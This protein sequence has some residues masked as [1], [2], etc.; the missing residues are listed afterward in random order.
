MNFPVIGVTG[1]PCSGKSY[2]AGLLAAGEVAGV[3]PGELLKA[4]DIGHEV[5]VRGDV[6]AELRKRF[7]DGLFAASDPATVRRAIAARVF[8]DAG[9]LAWLEGVVHPRVVAEVDAAVERNRGKRT[10]VMEAALLFT[11]GM[12]LR[13]DAVLL[14]EAEFDTRLRRAAA[15]GWGRDELERRERRQIPLF[16]AAKSGPDRDRLTTV[17]NDANDGALAVRIAAALAGRIDTVE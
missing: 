12:D 5:L 15:R 6:A 4:D 2:A 14:V 9:A 10:V 7:G 3:P 17:R 13:C 16:E 11:A 1:L 8:G